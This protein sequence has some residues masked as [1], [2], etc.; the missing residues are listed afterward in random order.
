MNGD[1]FSSLVYATVAHSARSIG[2]LGASGGATLV[3]TNPLVSYHHCDQGVRAK[4][5]VRAEV[6]IRVRVKIPGEP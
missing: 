5:K 2:S 3:S 4:A 1:F 6:R